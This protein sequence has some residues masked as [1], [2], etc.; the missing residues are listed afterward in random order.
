MRQLISFFLA[1]V[2]GL[3]SA[4]AY[5]PNAEQTESTQIQAA[6]LLNEDGTPRCR[7]GAAPELEDLRECDEGDELYARMILGNEEINLGAALP[8]GKAIAAVLVNL[9]I[10]SMSGCLVSNWLDR[11]NKDFK[12]WATLVGGLAITSIP[13]VAIQNRILAGLATTNWF[14][15]PLGV[16]SGGIFVFGTH[17]NDAN[18]TTTTDDNE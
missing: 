3:T 2:L 11:T 7:I 5:L 6:I 10:Y 14:E 18:E 16:A 4:H 12:F 13:A 17:C 1:T 15:I 8:P 9:G